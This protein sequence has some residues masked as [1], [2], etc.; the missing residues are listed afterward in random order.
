MSKINKL[1][2]ELLLEISAFAQLSPSHEVNHAINLASNLVA[3][4]ES[5]PVNADAVI[6]ATTPVVD[7]T[8]VA[9]EK[10]SETPIDGPHDIIDNISKTLPLLDPSTAVDNG[11][12]PESTQNNP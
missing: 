6:G 8:I 3:A 10:V 1:A 11:P 5:L 12:G 7:E 9:K 2:T 4:T